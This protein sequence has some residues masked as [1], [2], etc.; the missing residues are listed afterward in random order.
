MTPDSGNAAQAPV[1]SVVIPTFN[2]G[3]FIG[4]T[5]RS[6]QGQTLQQWECIVVD[7]GSTDNTAAVVGE[8]SARDPRV[9]YLRQEK[10]GQQ[11]AKNAGARRAIGQYVQFLDSDD[12][13]EPEKLQYQAAYLDAHQDVDVIY[14]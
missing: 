14:S 12:L 2:Y 4:E 10:R 6:V 8:I 1:V 7:D 11:A 13:I 5:L 3:H 9:K